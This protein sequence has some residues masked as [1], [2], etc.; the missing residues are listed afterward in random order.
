MYC[1]DGGILQPDC[2]DSTHA[3]KESEL[4]PLAWHTSTISGGLYILIKT[5]ILAV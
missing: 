3:I 1:T 5:L 4:R 2:L